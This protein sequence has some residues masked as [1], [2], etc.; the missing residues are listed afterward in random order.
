MAGADE[1]WAARARGRAAAGEG[2]A[3][4]GEDCDFTMIFFFSWIFI[5]WKWIIIEFHKSWILSMKIFKIFIKNWWIKFLQIYKWKKKLK[6]GGVLAPCWR[7]LL[8]SESAAAAMALLLLSREFYLKFEV[9]QQAFLG[10]VVAIDVD[11]RLR[12]TIRYFSRLGKHC[13]PWQWKKNSKSCAAPRL[14]HFRFISSRRQALL[15]K[16]MATE[17]TSVLREW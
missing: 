11:N 4:Q 7:G 5:G 3:D 6:I 9:S 13:I 10:R 1:A 12:L 17:S 2:G 16:Q 8:E 15:W 14:L